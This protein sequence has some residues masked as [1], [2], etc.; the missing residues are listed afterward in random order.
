MT[1]Q[2]TSSLWQ[3]A[4]LQMEGSPR[5]GVSWRP[6]SSEATLL[7]TC[8]CGGLWE[9]HWGTHT[10]L[11]S[12]CPPSWRIWL[13]GE[14]RGSV[15]PSTAAMVG[16]QWGLLRTPF[17]AALNLTTGQALVASASLVST[18]WDSGSRSSF[19]R[20]TSPSPAR[21]GGHTIPS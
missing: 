21:E 19:P 11:P 16:P 10:A 4:V 8:L 9:G 5:E 12:P 13:L 20:T 3:G 17:R 15:S 14:W 7:P 1:Q 2:T 6:N 18:A